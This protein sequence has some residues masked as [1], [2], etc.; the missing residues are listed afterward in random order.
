MKRISLIAFVLAATVSVLSTPSH[1]EDVNFGWK[2]TNAEEAAG[3]E[4]FKKCQACHSLDR[5]KNTFGPTLYGVYGRK[6]A[7]VP[8][9]AYSEALKNT[10]FTWDEEMLRKWVEGNT[11]V[12]SG[13]RMRHVSVVDPVEQDY[14]LAFLKSL[15]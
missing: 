12:V 13:T 10:D 8:R 6:S 15:K 11:W 2:P 3:R 7:S 14:L 1:A 5:S 4:V 9:F